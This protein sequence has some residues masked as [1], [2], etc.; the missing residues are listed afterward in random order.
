MGSDVLG[1]D[2]VGR[3]DIAVV[4]GKGANLGELARIDGISVPPGFCVT[5][6]AFRR[7]AMPADVATAITGALAR[8]GE[9]DAYA[10]RSSATAEDSATTSFA[11]QHDSFL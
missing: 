9:Q 3:T 1:L 6:A 5:T 10:V 8:L 7:A 4:G 11:G 2:E